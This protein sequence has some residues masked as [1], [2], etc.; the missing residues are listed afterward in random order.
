M[1]VI[2]E[3]NS[4]TATIYIGPVSRVSICVINN[5]QDVLLDRVF[6]TGRLD[7]K[8]VTGRE[9]VSVINAKKKW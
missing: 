6:E 8:P 7:S 5:K 1:K 9:V 2:H 3:R 4:I